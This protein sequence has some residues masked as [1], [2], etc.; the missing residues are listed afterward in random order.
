[1]SGARNSPTIGLKLRAL[2]LAAVC[3]AALPAKMSAFKS[4]MWQ[5]A[6]STT[7]TWSAS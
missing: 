5:N 7:V 2:P 1:M 6:Y 3:L 4:Y